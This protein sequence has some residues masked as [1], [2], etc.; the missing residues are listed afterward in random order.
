MNKPQVIVEVMGINWG[1]S[2]FDEC[3]D[4]LVFF[5]ANERGLPY[6][7]HIKRMQAK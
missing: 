5:W 1:D 2:T 7:E 6:I 4:Q 3:A